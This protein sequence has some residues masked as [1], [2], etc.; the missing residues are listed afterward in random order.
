MKIIVNSLRCDVTLKIQELLMFLSQTKKYDNIPSA[1][2]G[3]GQG[4]PSFGGQKLL[5]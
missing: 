3:F 5:T 1:D 4:C 2:P